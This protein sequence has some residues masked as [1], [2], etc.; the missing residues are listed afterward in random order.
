MGCSSG[1]GGTADDVLEAERQELIV[2]RK[3]K[4]DIDESNFKVCFLLARSY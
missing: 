2:I 4:D 3:E 1:Y